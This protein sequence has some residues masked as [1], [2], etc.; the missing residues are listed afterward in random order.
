MNKKIFTIGSL[1][2][3]SICGFS[4][5]NVGIGTI[6]PDF[7]AL[8][9]LSSTTSGLL[10]PRMG[11]LARLNIQNPA[12]GLLVYQTDGSEGF[13]YFDGQ[14]WVQALGP[15]GPTGPTGPSGAAGSN[16]PTGP[17]GPTGVAGSAG[18]TGPSG[19]NGVTGPTGPS[20]ADGATGQPGPTG[21]SGADGA[22]GQPGPTGPSGAD[23]ATG[24]NGVTGPTGPTGQ[25]GVTGPTGQNGVTGPTGPTGSFGPG[26]TPPI[27][28]HSFTLPTNPGNSNNV[29]ITFNTGISVAQ[30]DC[31]TADWNSS[32]DI[33]E[34]GRR[35]RIQWTYDNGG[36]WFIRYTWSVHSDSPSMSNSDVKLVCFDKA[37]VQWNGNPRTLNNSY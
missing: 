10:I 8:L 23:G 3:L 1:L 18:P 37:W 35:R 7:S 15:A 22:T 21:P 17:T 19:A 13:W 25:N 2:L 24:Q 20:G 30:F 34:S 36:T 32:F 27:Q 29:D 12:T 14:V 6:T 4:Q 26:S 33:H 11:Q 16:G 5:N 31:V 28:I 9:D